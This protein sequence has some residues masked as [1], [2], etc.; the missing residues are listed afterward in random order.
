MEEEAKGSEP[1]PASP[2]EAAPH[3][4]GRS[5]P[6][7]RSQRVLHVVGAD[8]V[9]KVSS[10]DAS[11]GS[12]DLPAE[13]WKCGVMRKKFFPPNNLSMGIDQF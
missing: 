4:E 3:G 13:P 12:T 11:A 6:A 1:V 10:P 9:R 8:L 2:G 5:E 7:L